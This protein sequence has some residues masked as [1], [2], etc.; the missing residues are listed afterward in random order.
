[1]HKVVIYKWV[2]EVLER[3]EKLFETIGEAFLHLWNSGA[4][5]GKIYDPN[6][7]LVHSTG[8]DCEDAYATYA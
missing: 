8:N 7:N 3:T 5:S 4:S 2:E 6:G 1:M